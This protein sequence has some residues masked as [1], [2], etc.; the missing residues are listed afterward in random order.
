MPVAALVAAGDLFG[1]AGNAVRVTLT[2][3]VAAGKVERDE[4]G[5]Y[6]LSGAAQTVNRRV[7]GWRRLDERTR[8]WDGGWVGIGLPSRNGA[9]ERPRHFL[10]IRELWPGLWIRP[11]NLAG[12]LGEVRSA[13]VELGIQ[14]PA[15]VFRLTELAAVDERRARTL[16]DPSGL[17]RDYEQSCLQLAHSGARLATLT[18]EEAMVESFALGGRVIR[19]LARDPLLPDAIAATGPRDALVKELRRYDAIGRACWAGFLAGFGVTRT[20]APMQ[21]RAPDTAG[22]LEPARG[23]AS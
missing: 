1:I 20:Q 2:R 17:R 23:G 15:L 16:W 12:G 21:L 6:R 9:T 7:T 10:G 14:T 3:L 5:R 18:T 13:L 19:E 4:R 22:W 8:A 11:D